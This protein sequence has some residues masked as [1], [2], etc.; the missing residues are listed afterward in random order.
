MAPDG[1][2][3]AVDVMSNRSLGLPPCLK[4]CA[5]DQF[6]FDC[7]EDSFNDG[8]RYALLEPMAQRA[9][10]RHLRSS[11]LTHP[12]DEADDWPPGPRSDGNVS[13]AGAD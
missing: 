13:V 7:L 8:V 6:R 5:P 9:D 3:E 1:I 12:L 4:A 10:V 11:V 2:V